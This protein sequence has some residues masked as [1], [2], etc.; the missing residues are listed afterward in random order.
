MKTYRTKPNQ[1]LCKCDNR[2]KKMLEIR[3]F[4]SSTMSVITCKE[5]LYTV[6]LSQ[7]R[8]RDRVSLCLVCPAIGY[9]K[10]MVSGQENDR[11]FGGNI[12]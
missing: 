11:H 9:E 12:K 10:I 7:L 4:W 3:S 5:A 2:K 6:K 8:Q 1:W